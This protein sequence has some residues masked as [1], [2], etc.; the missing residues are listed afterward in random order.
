MLEFY[1]TF[2]TAHFRFLLCLLLGP[3]AGQAAT[4]P[5]KI[6]SGL[7]QGLPVDDAGVQAFRGIPFAAAPV[8]DLRW[9]APQPVKAWEGVRPAVEFG[10]RPM[11]G[12]I[13]SDMVFRDAGPSEDCL[14]LNVWTPA[15]SDRERLPVM[16]WIYGGGLQAGGTSEPRQDGAI[17]ARKGVLVVSMNYR[18]GLFGFFSHPDLVRENKSGATGNYG[19]MDQIAALQWVQ[20]NIAAFGGDAHNV[21]I[22]GESAGSESVQVLV[23]SPLATGLFHKAIGQS[24]SFTHPAAAKG[25]K[26]LAR[27]TAEERSMK[28]ATA[29]GATSLNDLRA[30]SAEEL[31]K[32]ALA[33]PEFKAVVDGA[34][35]P[36]DTNEI[37]ATGRQAD[38]PLIAGWTADEGRVYEVFGNKRPT[39]ESFR[40]AVRKRHGEN[41][42][43]V[44]KLYSATTDEEAV[45]SAGDLGGERGTM[46]GMWKW[47]QLQNAHGRAPVYHYTFDRVVPI[48]PGREI[49]GAPATARDVGA[50]HASDIGYTFSAFDYA[51]NVPWQPVDRALSEVMMTYWSNFAK[52][53]N[54]NGS[55]VPEWP[56]YESKTHF[57]VMHLDENPQAASE[58]HRDR[59]EFFDAHGTG[60]HL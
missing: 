21:T 14:T 26:Q 56:R 53:G 57:A 6:D 58:A 38:V 27:I 49:N 45:R 15:K 4:A 18:L 28:F 59:Y 30:K 40:A 10:P 36:T 44:L 41:A 54:P 37:F 2:P 32:V 5:L 23:C 42:E 8:G 29:A 7:I 34:V 3:I 11:Q 17:L 33:A 20:R 47:M 43:A 50:V 51:K 55:G 24:G 1:Q 22:F 39:M 25:S 35:L 9:K 46:F 52:T 16:V 31:L 19:F 12:P 13:Y 48:A 60:E